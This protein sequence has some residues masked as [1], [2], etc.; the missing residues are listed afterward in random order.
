MITLEDLASAWAES[1]R[2]FHR[3]HAL[4][5]RLPE[6]AC[7]CDEPGICCMF[8]PEMT[9]LEAMQWI[10]LMQ[11]MPDHELTILIRR[12]VAFYLTNPARFQGCPFKNDKICSVYRYRTFGC[13]A[14]GLWGQRVGRMRT[15][16]SR[17]NR[18]A[19]RAMW[20]RYGIKLPTSVVEFEMDYCGEV[21]I[22][23]GES[24]GDDRIMNLLEKVYEL[25]NN[26]GDLQT[27]FEKEYHSDFSFLTTSLALGMRKA[28]LL[29]FAVVKEIVKDG[30]D[31]RL[32]EALVKVSPD[33]LRFG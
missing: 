18:K 1:K 25:D 19:L 22:R 9:T 16:E 28:V 15:E 33:V 11:V 13:R 31:M 29:K 23:S 32:Q 21:E 10:D 7:A 2:L 4:Y 26:L 3:L 6:T 20:Q 17:A 12:F 5:D 8:L 30:T 27:R 14:Y 24:I